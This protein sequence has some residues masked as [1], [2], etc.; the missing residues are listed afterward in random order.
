MPRLK[1]FAQAWGSCDGQ[2]SL[3]PVC[4]LKL[5]H[6]SRSH[7][8]IVWQAYGIRS[9]I[10]IPRSTRFIQGMQI[11]RAR[12]VFRSRDIKKSKKNPIFRFQ[13]ATGLNPEENLA[14]LEKIDIFWHFLT[15][16]DSKTV[17]MGPIFDSLRYQHFVL[18]AVRRVF[19]GVGTQKNLFWTTGS[20][21]RWSFFLH[22]C[23]ETL[24]C[25]RSRHFFETWVRWAKCFPKFFGY[26]SGIGGTWRPKDVMLKNKS[27]DS[28][29]VVRIK[30]LSSNIGRMTDFWT[31]QW[32]PKTVKNAIFG[33]KKNPE[34]RR[35]F[36]PVF[37]ETIFFFRKN[38]KVWVFVIQR[39]VFSEI[40]ERH[41]QIFSI[42]SDP[43]PPRDPGGV[44]D[45][46]CLAHPPQ[47]SKKRGYPPFWKFLTDTT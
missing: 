6:S 9:Y 2:L 5:T 20:L 7:C 10:F 11:Q 17:P 29:N 30:F 32:G 23:C 35:F 43:G 39:Q 21:A 16:R 31:P 25:L 45:P 14:K 26:S 3:R 34:F 40:E 18:G 41:Y 24:S 19:W 42:P 46:I 36:D 28:K 4:V 13:R 38:Q 37:L 8:T 22:W 12:C 27:S 1:L 47:I 15:P 44:P 33:S